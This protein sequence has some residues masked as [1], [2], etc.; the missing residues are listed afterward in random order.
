M[1]G[2]YFDFPW[3]ALLP[4]AVGGIWMAFTRLDA[5]LLFL[6]AAVPLSLNLEDMELGGL[7]VYLP[8]EPLLAGLLLLFIL[9][10]MR[11]FPVD[12][13]LLRHPLTF[14]IAASLLWIALTAIVSEHPVVSFL[15]LIHI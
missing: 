6:V 13:R 12:Q 3:L 11:G 4:L 7:G 1:L 8:T 2:V 15:S 14:W 10:A 5:L 9:R